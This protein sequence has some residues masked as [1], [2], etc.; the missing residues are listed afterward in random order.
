MKILF[1]LKNKFIIFVGKLVYIL[2]Q[3]S[4]RYRIM[5]AEKQANCKINYVC[6]G[7]GGVEIGNPQN[8]KIH[9]TSHLKSNTYIE[10]LGGV[11]IGA[12]F[13]TGRGLTIFSSNHNYQSKNSIPYDNV[14]ILG[15]VI[16][17]DF[18]WCGANVTILANVRVGEGAVIGANSVITK[19]VPKY[20]IVA[21]NPAKIIKY[22]DVE[23]FQRIKAANKFF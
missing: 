2:I 12:Y 17:E 13:H 19:D 1:A 20:A 16:I 22:R 4:I 11:E 3:C 23:Q 21:G 18:V 10:C 5:Y 7:F 15:P 9:P 14:N 8:F 6:Q